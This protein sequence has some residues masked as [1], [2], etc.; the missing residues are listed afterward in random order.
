M[1]DKY[2]VNLQWTNK[3]T[4]SLIKEA[5]QFYK[6]NV[7]FERNGWKHEGGTFKEA[8]I[9]GDVVVKFG[10]TEQLQA[11]YERWKNYRGSYLRKYLARVYGFD[12]KMLIQRRVGGLLD[13]SCSCDNS[14]YIGKL[15]G[16][17]IDWEMNH[18]H[19]NGKPVFFDTDDGW[20]K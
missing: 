2:K 5:V 6:D 9:K 18:G 8:Y 14:R 17:V 3:K 7:D 4:K 12:G 16:F 1:G 11:E 15:I 20:K 19:E 10:P 13:D